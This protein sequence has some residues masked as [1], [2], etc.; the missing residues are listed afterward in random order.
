M[1]VGSPE[2]AWPEV[3]AGKGECVSGGGRCGCA[4]ALGA[5]G[6]GC[7]VDVEGCVGAPPDN[8]TMPDGM[9]EAYA[10]L[11]AESVAC[12]FTFDSVVDGA[13]LDGEPLRVYTNNAS[14]WRQP[15]HVL[16]DAPRGRATTLALQGRNPSW[17]R[18]PAL[19]ESG[20]LFAEAGMM[21]ACRSCRAGWDGVRSSELAM[22]TRV[23]GVDDAAADAPAGWQA[24]AFDD[25]AWDV[26]AVSQ[27]DFACPG[28]GNNGRGEPPQ[29]VWF[30]M[31][32]QHAL[33]RVT[34]PAD[35]MG[36]S[37]IVTA[38]DPRVRMADASSGG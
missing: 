22:D 24:T 25:A 26:P 28:C 12:S 20:E 15:K 6:D 7:E 8:C 30:A 34:P 27:A 19:V 11:G 10:K 35:D 2:G 36:V 3:C 33:F 37:S 14:D 31:M 21:L 4:C 13:W 38:R 23:L 18:Q 1:P 9:A 16:F 5:S 29:K 17:R 32:T